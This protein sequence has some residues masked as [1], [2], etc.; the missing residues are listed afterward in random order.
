MHAL[1]IAML[2]FMPPNAGALSFDMT[3]SQARYIRASLD[4]LALEEMTLPE[5]EEVGD[6]SSATSGEPMTGDEGAAG[7]PDE[8]RATGGQIRVRGESADTRV[9]LTAS[10]VAHSS[11]ISAISAALTLGM[12]S[13]ISSPFGAADALGAFDQDAYGALMAEQAGFSPG[14]GGFGMRGTGRGAGGLAD[15]TVGWGGFGSGTG[16]GT[17]TAFELQTLSARIGHDAAVQQCAAGS[18]GHGHGVGTGTMEDPTRHPRV[19]SPIS[20]HV[21]TAG[22]LTMEEVRRVVAR[23]RGQ[24]RFCYEQALTSRPDLSGRVSVRW[25]VSPDGHVATSG[26]DAS[27]TD[28][29]ASQVESCVAQAVSRWTFPA[30]DGPTAVTY[31]FVLQTHE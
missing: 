23:Q 3:E 8:T 29:H 19:P 5:P 21:E 31:P 11:A 12:A 28:I 9:P 30:G 22:G 1:L 24:I 13:S 14:G 16:T 17:C 7:A 27:R 4:A 18:F 26:I 2:F 20:T 10:D 25:V 6:E 15:G